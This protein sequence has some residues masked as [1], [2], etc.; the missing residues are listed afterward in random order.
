MRAEHKA[1]P[2]LCLRLLAIV[3]S[4]IMASKARRS[5]LSLGGNL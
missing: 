1:H 5:N 4:I 2:G 3:E